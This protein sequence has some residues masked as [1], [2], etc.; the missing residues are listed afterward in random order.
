MSEEAD[1]EANQ[2]RARS[3]RLISASAIMMAGTLVSRI[4][5]FGRLL[6]L[7]FLFG[8]GTRQAD[9]FAVANAVPT[10]M[11]ILLVGGVLNTVLVPQIVRAVKS[12]AD[13]GEAYTNRIMTGGLI[14]LF[15]I[16]L[17]LTLA[18][19]AIISLYSAAG[20]K[21][22]DIAAQYSSMVTLGYY[23]MPQ[24]FFYGVYVLAG[25]VLNARDRFG[26]M[27]WSPI[28]NN[29]IF[30]AVLLIFLGV[31]GQTNPNAA[32][33]PGQELLLGLGSTLGIAAQAVLLVPFLRSVG[34]R[35]APRFDFRGT[36]LGKTVRL[37]KWTLGFVLVTQAGLVV[38]NKVATAATVDG[39]GGG[40]AAY[41][42]AYAVF[43][44]PHS[45]ITVS[46][47]T[48]ML[49]S[50]SRL[51]AAGDLP[52]VAAEVGR[53]WRLALTALL[54]AAIGFFVLGVPI[55]RLVFG[56]G[57]GSDDADFTGWAL[58]TLSLGLVPFT[59]QYICL[60]AFYALE[61]TRTPFFL[62]LL[63]TGCYVSLGVLVSTIVDSNPLVAACLGSGLA[64][65]YLIG[66]FASTRVLKRSL[67]DLHLRPLARLGGRLLAA[68]VP[69]MAV[70]G[71]L[72]WGVE[73][74]D[75]S[76][77]VR[78][79]AI[80]GGV[81]IALGAFLGMSRLLHVAEVADI[82]RTVLRK[83]A[84]AGPSGGGSSQSDADPAFP[85]D[86]AAGR[87]DTSPSINEAAPQEH[88]RQHDENA[89]PMGTNALTPDLEAGRPRDA[90]TPMAPDAYS[91]DPHPSFPASINA[92]TVLAARYRL[93]ELL[94]EAPPTATWRAFD[95]VLSRSVLLHLLPPHEENAV[96]L[97]NLARRAAVATD[98]RFL[99]VLDAVYSDAD[100]FGSYIV[101]EYATGQSLEVLLSHGPLS[102]LEAAWVVREV[103][104][105]LSGVHSLGLYHQR[106]NPD[107]VV[108]T[109]DGHVK[110]VGLLIEQALR[111]APGS[112][113]LGREAADPPPS[114]EA[115][116]VADLG[117]LLY[118]CLV[119][120]WP[121]GPAFSLPAAPVTG[122][123]WLSPRQVRAGVSP[124][125]D[126]ICDQILG[127]PPR[128]RA[129]RLSTANE[130]VNALTGVLGPA[131]ASGDLERRL[132]QPVPLVTTTPPPAPVRTR[133]E[134]GPGQP[135]ARAAVAPTAYAPRA[136]GTRPSHPVSPTIT[137]EDVTR[138]TVIRQA[139][140]PP[141]VRT[142]RSGAPRRW[143][144]VVALM[145]LLLIAT[146]IASAVILRQRGGTTPAVAQSAPRDS[147][148]P[149]AIEPPPADGIASAREFDPQGD[150]PHTENPDE[151]RLAFDGSPQTRWRTVNYYGPELGG[152]KR[153]VGLVFDLG[154]ARVLRE[155]RIRLSGNGTNVQA[156]IPKT[157]AAGTTKPPMSS[158]AR[159]R[160]VSTRSQAGGS[161]TLRLEEPATTRFVLVYLTS[162]PKEGSGYR[163][164]IYE[165]EV[166]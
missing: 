102:G 150:P 128:R 60:R 13:G 52:G 23:C 68:F 1:G 39:D 121:G 131:D 129:P 119:S 165:V 108:L 91:S 22:P 122:R 105:A 90:L 92:G 164:G 156:R 2:S 8:V 59:L 55:A 53:T 11:Y 161:A 64:M 70:A 134:A 159:W 21:D 113:L 63:I 75:P 148:S 15:V 99:R 31:F 29:V 77:L 51:A 32:F 6:L 151:I 74:S 4:V 126:I 42:Y 24:V 98:S 16:T 95:L 137:A 28:A 86:S 109:P 114:P 38:I 80:A 41:S 141:P 78:A 138:V 112:A 132:R 96:E 153:G 82:V 25:Q 117:R 48:A 166:S 120:R 146:G 7:A 57:A 127:D 101:C 158:D 133:A 54:P 73:S 17:A 103:A 160:T 143:I 35:F 118:A 56:F 152:I 10:S 130:V 123:H 107:T 104:D 81:V 61:N 115:V 65:A 62:Q 84:S 40:L 72:V 147:A 43:V 155:V 110:I 34:Y 26:P 76:Q 46:L 162:L 71:G 12:D 27:M 20:W 18:V 36:G 163:G 83:R 136:E 140:P 37:A 149:P 125:L 106:I 100:D 142:A 66:V 79:L 94:A 116:D 67:P 49:P 88:D 135:L 85:G 5:G 69:G 58:M 47:A 9:M 154:E 19:P 3:A 124:A 44:V 50:A 33:T 144:A 30:I 45:L 87:P 14:V 145:A 111:P 97:L 157:D 139:P 93:E 89:D